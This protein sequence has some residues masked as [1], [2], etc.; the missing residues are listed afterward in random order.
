MKGVGVAIAL[1]FAAY[2]T[3]QYFANGKYTDAAK[4]MVTQMRHSTGIEIAIGYAAPTNHSGP[5]ATVVV[6]YPQRQE[7]AFGHVRKWHL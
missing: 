5:H 3:D 6:R 4:R 1:L 7:G 2:L